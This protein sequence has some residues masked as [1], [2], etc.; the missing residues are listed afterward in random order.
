MRRA[1]AAALLLLAAGAAVAAPGV[2]GPDYFRGLYEQVGRE[3]PSPGA[4]LDG[5]LRIEPA[6][7]GLAAFDCRGQ[8]L[9]MR[10]DPWDGAEN[11]IVGRDRAGG[12]FRCLFHNNGDNFPILTCTT[13]AGGRFT[14]WPAVETFDA[15]LACD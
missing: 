4:P 12:S 8:A 14:L 2:P 6:G 5:M 10:F 15:A 13:E 1:G 3:G 7:Q 9:A 11:L